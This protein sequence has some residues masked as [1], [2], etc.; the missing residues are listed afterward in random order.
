MAVYTQLEFA[1][2]A[3]LVAP[4]ALGR[5]IAAGGVA[6]G[7]ENTTYFLEFARRSRDTAPSHSEDTQQK[8]VLT[9][10]ET[11][12]RA[13]LEFIATLTHDLNLR[14]LPIPAP[15]FVGASFAG[16]RALLSIRDKPALLVPKIAGAHPQ[17][18]SPDLC[19]QVG[20]LLAELHLA[21]LSLGYSHT[22]HRSLNW[23][24]VTGKTLLPHL[25]ETQ[26]TLLNQELAYLSEFVSANN[27]LPQ[28]IIHGDLFRD[29]VLIKDGCVTAIIDFFSAGTGYL[30]LDLAIAVNDWCFD[31]LGHL[32][33]NNYKGLVSAYC[34][35][36][37]P[38]SQEIECWGQ[39]LRI[40]ALRFWVSRLSEQLIPGP[41]TPPGRGKDPEPYH[42][43]LRLHRN[44]PLQLSH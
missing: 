15:V 37:K 24:A 29:N 26:H 30:L 33:L 36:R 8:Y 22:S 18:A 35:V 10:A 1:E 17:V 25:D 23:V 5:L 43:L 42:R 2:I 3:A 11:L 21:T 32:N 13:D 6:A 7:V 34:S 14:G 20:A 19:R 9:I 4:L 41:H 39:L 12:S 16:S 28:A 44:T 27:E 40:A 31:A 38:K